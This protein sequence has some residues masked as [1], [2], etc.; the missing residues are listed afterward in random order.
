MPLIL[1][2]LTLF[3]SC[4]SGEHDAHFEK[5]PSQLIR[6]KLA[7]YCEKGSKVLASRGGWA[8]DECDGLLFTSLFSAACGGPGVDAYESTVEPGQWFRN[9]AKDCFIP[10]KVDNKSDST[11]SKDMYLGL[12]AYL[13]HNKKRDVLGRTIEY[14][15]NHSWVVGEAADATTQA[16][17]CFIT[18]SLQSLLAEAYDYA[19]SGSLQSPLTQTAI[20]PL[21][22]GF[23][24]HLDVLAILVRGK[25][26]GHVD[27][28]DLNTLKDQARRQPNN[29]LFQIAKAKYDD[30]DF[31]K[32]VELLLDKNHWPETELPTNKNHC[33]EYLWQRDDDPSDWAPCDG[34]KTYDGTDFV[35]AAAVYLGV[36]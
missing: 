28:L 21:S 26:Q 34:D 27:T 35:F 8:V 31:S 11:I 30:A 19:G 20:L 15:K 2:I 6:E 25:V 12:T 1:C 7:V 5:S 16:S 32:A 33:T 13:A 4:S 17:K 3:L 22:T 18:P 24:A 36:F 14:G 10:D 23:R 9:P 29:A